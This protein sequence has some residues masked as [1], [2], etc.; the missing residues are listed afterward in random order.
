MKYIVIAIYSIAQLFCSQNQSTSLSDHQALLL[1]QKFIKTDFKKVEIEDA[2]AIVRY[3]IDEKKET[4]DSLLKKLDETV[5]CGRCEG[6]LKKFYLGIGGW[7]RF[8]GILKDYY[9]RTSKTSLV[10]PVL[11]VVTKETHWNIWPFNRLRSYSGSSSSSRESNR[12]AGYL[13]KDL[14][15]DEETKPLIEKDKEE[16]KRD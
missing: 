1:E 4:L 6:P 8:C 9:T 14:D 13:E 3:L 12:S 16:K 2:R 7:G 11:T 10:S 5:N 15:N